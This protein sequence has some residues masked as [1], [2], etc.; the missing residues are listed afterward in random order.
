[1]GDSPK[2]ISF[3]TVCIT[4]WGRGSGTKSK[5]KLEG[6]AFCRHHCLYGIRQANLHSSL[7][8][9]FGIIFSGI[10]FQFPNK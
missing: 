6:H 5:K 2:V 8:W 7:L 4:E 10:S 9:F 1:M 3:D